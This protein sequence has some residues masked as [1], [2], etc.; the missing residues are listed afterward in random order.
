MDSFDGIMIGAGMHLV[1]GKCVNNPNSPN[2]LE[3]LQ[4][5]V[6]RLVDKDDTGAYI[7]LD[8]LNVC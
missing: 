4:A 8:G 2:T 7:E 1:N 6:K 5:V 3:D